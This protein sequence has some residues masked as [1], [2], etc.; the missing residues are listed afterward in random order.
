MGIAGSAHLIAQRFRQNFI[1][2]W[3]PVRFCFE[4]A[5]DGAYLGTQNVQAVLIQ[6]VI[7]R[8]NANAGE[9]RNHSGQAGN[10]D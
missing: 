9:Y 6:N 7:N 2:E 3:G 5:C 8:C 1:R 10:R 4:C